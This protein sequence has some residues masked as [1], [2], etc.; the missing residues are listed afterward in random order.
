MGEGV[1]WWA[2]ASFSDMT[3]EGYKAQM[4]LSDLKLA[5]FELHKGFALEGGSRLDA[6]VAWEKARKAAVALGE[7]TEKIDRNIK[8]LND[9]LKVTPEIDFSWTEGFDPV[10]PKIDKITDALLGLTDASYDV[11]AAMAPFITALGG[12]TFTPPSGPA[13]PTP[14]DY[15]LPPT[16]QQMQL[17]HMAEAGQVAFTHANSM[18]FTSGLT[19]GGSKTKDP[20][21]DAPPVGAA[22]AWADLH[23]QVKMTDEKAEEFTARMISDLGHDAT[24]AIMDFA[25]GAASAEEAFANFASSFL[26][27]MAEMI[28]QQLVFNA[29]SGG[30]GL[31]GFA[32]G[33]T[34]EGGMSLFANGGVAAGGLGVIGYANGGP[35]VTKPHLAM[36]GEG[37]YDEAVVPL[38]GG[39][40]IPVQM[41]G[42]GGGAQVTINVQA[43]D[44]ADA[45]RVL[46]KNSGAIR[47]I[48]EDAL[49]TTQS[50]R[51]AVRQVQ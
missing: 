21:K 9:A 20:T 51:N 42:G 5:A 13:V 39:G 38:T 37:H 18:L 28:T 34:A 29:I 26:L 10:P 11:G 7:D 27:G 43:M 44:G 8:A 31:F 16:P 12:G 36:V 40:S 6:L 30:A 17:G 46:M 24:N 50:T 41:A 25:T 48:F 2:T 14:G 4:A 35:I 23:E 45:T 33:G 47:S 3:G 32:D 19:A 15:K 1:Q 49:M 22:K